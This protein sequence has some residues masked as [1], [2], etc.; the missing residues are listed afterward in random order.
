MSEKMGATEGTKLT[1]DY[2]EMEQVT[3]DY[4]KHCDSGLMANV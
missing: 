1:A 2:G 4:Y 3:T